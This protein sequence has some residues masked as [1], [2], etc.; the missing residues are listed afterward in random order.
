MISTI[1]SFNAFKRFGLLSNAILTPAAS[2][3][4]TGF[5]GG[6]GGIC[7]NDATEST[8]KY[9][10][11]LIDT[12]DCDPMNGFDVDGIHASAGRV[13]DDSQLE[14]CKKKRVGFKY[15]LQK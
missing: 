13:L 3:T 9:K 14:N 1:S 6:N 2:S 11:Q 4:A 8:N 5:C 12:S 10:G 15:F 7:Y